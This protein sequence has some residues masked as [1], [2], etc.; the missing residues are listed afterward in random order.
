MGKKHF[1]FDV[2]GTLVDSEESVLASMQ[3]M[4]ELRT[5]KRVEK[6]EL[7]FALG[8]PGEDALRRL[9]FPESELEEAMEQWLGL[10]SKYR[11]LI[12]VFPGIRE[13]L[14]GLRRRGCRL[15]IVTS[16]TREEYETDVAPFGLS[17]YFDTIVCADDTQ[18]HKPQGAPVREYLRRMKADPEE[19]VYIGDTVY[20]MLCAQ[21]AG[22]EG[23]AGSMGLRQRQAYPGGLLSGP[24]GGGGGDLFYAGG[25]RGTMAE[26]GQGAAG[27]RPGRADLFP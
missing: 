20:D 15:G 2:D 3:E 24:A 21:D 18:G 8:I 1:I 7:S 22:V 17:E 12:H 23:G 10:T 14:A 13:T 26:M 9:H 27:Y 16:R 5:G 6:K 11:K 19:A 25:G 4:L